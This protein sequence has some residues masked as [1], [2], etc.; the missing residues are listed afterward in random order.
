MSRKA[1]DN[2]KNDKPTEVNPQ[3]WWQWI[4]VYPALAIAL[5]GSIPTFKELYESISLGVE[6]GSSKKAKDQREMWEKNLECTAAPFDWLR[7]SK[8]VMVDATICPSGDVFVRVKAPENKQFYEWVAVDSF[9]KRTT[10][11][12]LISS[13]IAAE[14]SNEIL[15]AQFGIQVICQRWMDRVMLLR[16][17]AVPGQGCFDEVVNTYS[18]M[19]VSQRPA[20]CDPRC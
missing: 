15:I 1:G 14:E 3:K 20:P 4:L 8:N 19:V 13:A 6:Y 9:F 2:F 11:I 12:S 5:L 17:V 10:S 18:G 7:T 16:R